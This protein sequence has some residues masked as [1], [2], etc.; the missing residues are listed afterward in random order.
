[1]DAVISYV[2]GC[3]KVWRT[4]FNK[5]SAFTP[6]KYFRFYD[7]GTLKYV[8]RGISQYMPYIDNVFLV[9]SNIEQVPDYVDQ[10]KV[11]IVLHKDFI[12]EEYLPT[13]QPNAIEIFMHMISGLG[14]EFVYFNDDMIPVSPISYND[15]IQDNKPCISFCENYAK[16]NT[17]SH[18]RIYN[19]YV[20]ANIYVDI[21]KSSVSQ[22]KKNDMGICPTHSPCVFL[23]L[24]NAN[25]YEVMKHLFKSK[26]TL[27]RNKNGINQY[28]YSD[29]LYLKKEY[30]DSKLTLSYIRTDDLNPDTINDDFSLINTNYLCVNDFGQIPGFTLKESSD[31]LQK[32]LDIKLPQKCKYEL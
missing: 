16:Q 30:M 21:Y 8:L 26:I 25:V 20:Y 15:L 4:E 5:Y 28:V 31:I 24:N 10:T 1:M 14:E 29:V 17:M 18:N 22:L 23:K 11:K 12:P 2:N 3:E 32:V 7:W 13:F 27:E 6:S 9:V 19:S